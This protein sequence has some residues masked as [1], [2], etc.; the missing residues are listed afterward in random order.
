[1]RLAKEREAEMPK[2]GP[3]KSNA[4]AKPTIDKMKAAKAKIR[5]A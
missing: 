1:M 4:R 5:K 2:K 3:A